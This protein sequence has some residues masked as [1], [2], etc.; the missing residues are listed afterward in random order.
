[1]R[2]LAFAARIAAAMIAVAAAARAGSSRLVY[3]RAPDAS[4]C[5]DEAELRKAVARRF[6]Y[7]PFFPW[8]KQTVVVQIFRARARYVARV[9]F[10]DEQGI[11][12][13]T[14]EL[15]SNQNDC[16][17]IFEA[18]ALAVSIALDRPAKPQ[19]Q[20]ARTEEPSPPPAPSPPAPPPQTVSAPPPEPL[21]TVAS[22]E[23]PIPA[24]PDAAARAQFD[25][26]AD[27]L[28]SAGVTPAVTPGVSGFARARLHMWSLSLE[29]RADLPESKARSIDFGGGSV[30]V[31]TMAGGVAPCMHLGYLAGCAVGWIGAL[32]ASGQGVAQPRAATTLLLAVGARLGFEWP[33]S[34]VLALR[35]HVE[36]VANLYPPT[37]VLGRDPDKVWSAPAVAGTIGTGLAVRFQ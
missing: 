2:S 34:S 11:A 5:P 14:R 32:Q 27:V 20:A 6:G 31:W 22:S 8:A 7:D 10:L 1:M 35:A 13:G 37:L 30:E 26:G 12:Q 36:G 3:S 21:S 9:Q 28:A 17:E 16:L 4:S 24:K 33:F 19:T 15:T 25:V 29:V 18:S 23:R